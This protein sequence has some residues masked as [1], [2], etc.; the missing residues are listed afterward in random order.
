MKTTPTPE[1]FPV[2]FQPGNNAGHILEYYQKI[3][4]NFNMHTMAAIKR[5]GA[6]CP[7]NGCGSCDLPD[8]IFSDFIRHYWDCPNG[9]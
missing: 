8:C 2:Q 1:D 9:D 7:S 3:N 6:V 5:F 4:E